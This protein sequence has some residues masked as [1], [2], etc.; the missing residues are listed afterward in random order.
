MV[1]YSNGK[2]YML[3]SDR[4]DKVYIGGTTKKLCQRLATHKDMFKKFKDGKIKK[5]CS[6][7]DIL[8]YPDVCIVLLENVE[9]K[10]KDE[11]NSKIYEYRNKK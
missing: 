2:I 10:S 9:C 7:Y 3:K 4:T 8:Q 5:E 6:S 1:S 11:L